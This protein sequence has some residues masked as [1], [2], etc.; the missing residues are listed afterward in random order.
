ME[1]ANKTSRTLVNVI[2]IPSLL[3]IIYSGGI[4]FLFLFLVIMFIG[5]TE[6]VSLSKKKGADLFSPTLNQGVLG[7]GLLYYFDMIDHILPFIMII[8]I[9]VMI[10]EVF[11]S[12]KSPFLNIAITSLAMIW[13]GLLIGSMIYIRNEAGFII[14]LS[15]FLSVWTCDTFGFFFGKNFGKSKILPDVSPKKTWVG[16]IMGLVGSL[17]C[18]LI[19]YYFELFASLNFCD[20]L[21]IGV[22]CGFFGQLG[23]FAESALKRDVG[24]KDSGS[25]LRGH[26]G[27]LDRFDSLAFAAP[28]TLLYLK[29]FTEIFNG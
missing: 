27:V 23:D 8:M 16:S 19:F 3:F 11:R 6:L 24:V 13:L 21:A 17:A 14:T 4:L 18:M 10:I 29:Y 9:G 7:I 5:S 26:G 22:I 1:N 20:V 25:F 2:G 28:L 12:S 15:I